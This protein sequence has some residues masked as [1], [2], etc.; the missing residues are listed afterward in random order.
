M[1]CKLGCIFFGAFLHQSFVF[2]QVIISWYLVNIYHQILYLCIQS[3]SPYI[4]I[5]NSFFSFFCA[6]L[7]LFLCIVY[8]FSQYLNV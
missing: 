1:D 4:I 6:L 2:F 5:Y 8:A 3:V 7:T